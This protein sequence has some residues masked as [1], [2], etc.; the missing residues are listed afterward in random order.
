MI[1]ILQTRVF[2]FSV[3][4]FRFV[5]PS[6]C[7]LFPGDQCRPCSSTCLPH[8]PCGTSLQNSCDLKQV[9]QPPDMANRSPGLKS[10]YSSSLSKYSC[11]RSY[12]RR[13]VFFCCCCFF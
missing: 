2:I 10:H 1:L 5:D 11:K 9:S 6:P 8:P 4:Y 13:E 3:K 7:Q 12:A